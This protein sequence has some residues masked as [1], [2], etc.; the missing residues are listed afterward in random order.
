VK[1]GTQTA[2][3]PPPLDQRDELTDSLEAVL[4]H[5]AAGH[6]LAALLDGAGV[7]A[8][9]VRTLDDVYSWEQVRSQGL[10]I[11]L[12]HPTFGRLELPGPTIRF[13]DLGYAGG[14]RV[15]RLRR[16]WRTTD[17]P[18]AGSWKRSSRAPSDG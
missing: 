7:P 3:D 9:K 18:Y 5:E 15:M 1:D 11:E 16:G 13:D 14:V 8:G 17:P 6:W 2:P 4:V 10:V 12:D